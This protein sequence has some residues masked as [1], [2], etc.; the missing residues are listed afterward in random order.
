M[1]AETSETSWSCRAQNSDSVP[2][3]PEPW[4]SFLN[5]SNVMAGTESEFCSRQLHDVSD[6]S[7][8][9]I[10]PQTQDLS[11]ASGSM[12][13]PGSSVIVPNTFSYCSTE[14]AQTLASRF[15]RGRDI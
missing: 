13:S 8:N 5:T 11:R 3:L 9:M 15:I 1:F 2:A 14:L 10:A 6:V 4:F 12:R 7:A